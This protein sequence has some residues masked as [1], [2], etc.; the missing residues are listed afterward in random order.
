MHSTAHT[1]PRTHPRSAH[2]PPPPR[3]PPCAFSPSF[4]AARLPQV[5][6]TTES[7]ELGLWQQPVPAHSPAPFGDVE[8]AAAAPVASSTPAL[9][10]GATAGQAAKPEA[11]AVEDLA[12]EIITAEEDT[13]VAE[14]EGAAASASGGG[15]RRRLRKVTHDSDDGGFSDHD[16]DEAAEAALLAAQ[17]KRQGKGGAG[18]GAS[19]MDGRSQ[20][21]GF[22]SAAG[23]GG[24]EL[25]E[26]LHPSSTPK[27]EGAS[28]GR[29]FLL[30]NLTGM[31]LSRDEQTYSAIEVDFNNTEQHRTLRLT[32][33]YGFTMAALDGAAVIFGS[34]S[35][36]GNPS[37][38]V[39]RP[40]ASWAPNS[41][42]QV[43]F[44]KGEEAQ[45]VALGHKFAAVATS[46]RYLRVYSHTGAQRA[47]LCFNAPLVAMAASQGLLALV[48]HDGRASGADQS[49]QVVLFDMRDAARPVRLAT[50]PLPLSPGATLHWVGFSEAGGLSTVDSAGVVRQCMRANG[51]EWVPVLHCAA[52]KKSAQEHHWVVGLTDAQLMCV[53][54]KGD[55]A[56]PATLPR[57]VLSSLPL[58]MPLACAEPFE[59]K[60][61]GERLMTQLLLDEYRAVA[62]DDQDDG[63]VQARLLKGF[64]KLDGVTIKL[65][66]HA[67]RSERNA[68]ALDLATQLQLPKALQAALKIA[69][70]YKMAP[71]AERITMLL[72]AKFD[73]T[74]VEVE[75]PPPR[76]AAAPRAKPAPA[77]VPAAPA[78]PAAQEEEEG[79]DAD[80]EEDAAVSEAGEADTAENAPPQAASKPSNPFAKMSSGSTGKVNVLEL[81]A[82]P[83][84]APA[85][86]KRKAVAPAAGKTAK[87]VA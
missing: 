75:A 41:E 13:L 7:G 59:P 45:A 28:N 81:G 69:N 36:N 52:L 40:L 27:V 78:A 67:C 33:R 85:G 47:L 82:A 77:T 25:Q 76:A 57:P 21:G 42:W 55:D 65:M 2:G 15:I 5:S 53:I 34:R 1:R 84:T 32:D 17:L 8:A 70:H 60:L 24:A 10:P 31:V 16:D 11:A 26:V 48:Q 68:R 49:M 66:Q 71:L 79:A 80:D 86:S 39:Y 44:E 38:V 35:N 4:P 74:E 51:F 6:F 72:Q 37:T 87:K 64:T 22:L 29:R 46:L 30:W 83:G 43:Q 62:E 14:G 23:G 56:F 61:E 9:G 54:C 50:A 63:D 18:A 3:T 12:S 19:G 58:T 20:A 73:D